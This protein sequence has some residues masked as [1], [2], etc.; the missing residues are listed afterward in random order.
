MPTRNR[1]PRLAG[2]LIAAAALTACATPQDRADL[3]TV[4]ASAPPASLDFTTTGGAAAPQA[5][6]GNVYETLVR[7]DD[8]GTP[9]P[10]LATSWDIE[11]RPEGAVYTFHLRDDVTFSLSLIHI[12]EPTR[13]S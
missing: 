1:L 7:I 9:Q 4:A 12:S 5:L 8:T 6:M 13:R 3:L 10:F 11:E 2:P